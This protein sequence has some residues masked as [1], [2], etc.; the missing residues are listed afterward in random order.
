M[1]HKVFS[2][3]CILKY[4]NLKALL[5][6]SEPA[7]TTGEICTVP[8]A[9][10]NVW[11][12]IGE[13]ISTAEG[14]QE[15]LSSFIH[16]RK[17]TLSNRDVCTGHSASQTWH[18]RILIELNWTKGNLAWDEKKKVLRKKLGLCKMLTPSQ[19]F[20]DKSIY[21]GETK[22]V[23]WFSSPSQESETAVVLNWSVFAPQRTFLN[24][25][26]HAWLSQSG[27]RALGN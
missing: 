5:K 12:S 21:L 18:S 11:L 15:N 4:G 1:F 27:E 6:F 8:K 24:V 14:E 3:C 20:K 10:R 23:T 22:E 25:W 9:K 13:G 16:L 2:H 7:P 26:R 19:Q 17:K